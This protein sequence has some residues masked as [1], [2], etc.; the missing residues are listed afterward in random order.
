[1]LSQVIKNDVDFNCVPLEALVDVGR[2]D[3][4]SEVREPVQVLRTK[5]SCVAPLRD[6]DS[7]KGDLAEVTAG[8]RGGLE[9]HEVL[10][11]LRCY[12][13]NIGSYRQLTSV[14][15]THDREGHLP[16]AATHGLGLF[17][18]LGWDLGSWNERN[19]RR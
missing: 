13:S 10:A 3:Q 17:P 15:K 12:G 2:L 8:G 9:G 18:D 16:P 11:I 4:I 5:R 19:E 1:M 7:T 6:P 14:R